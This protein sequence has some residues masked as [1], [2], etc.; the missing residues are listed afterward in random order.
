LVFYPIL[1]I[2][3]PTEKSPD[4]GKKNPERLEKNTHFADSVEQK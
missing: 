3:F 4:E 2:Y 1:K